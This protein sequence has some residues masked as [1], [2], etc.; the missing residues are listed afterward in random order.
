MIMIEITYFGFNI[1][2]ENK[3]KNIIKYNL[4]LSSNLIRYI[5]IYLRYA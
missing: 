2:E 4:C 3:L 1:I 5:Y